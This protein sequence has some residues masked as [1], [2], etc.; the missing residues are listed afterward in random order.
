MEPS[1]K[2]AQA[3]AARAPADGEPCSTSSILSLGFM[4]HMWALPYSFKNILFDSIVR[5]AQLGFGVAILGHH[6]PVC[7]RPDRAG[8]RYRGG[9]RGGLHGVPDRLE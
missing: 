6:G 1:N 9:S 8:P 3:S 2:G 5:L 4:I 7:L